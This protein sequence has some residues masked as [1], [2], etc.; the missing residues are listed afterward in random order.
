MRYFNLA[1]LFSTLIFI[2]SFAQTGQVLIE[3]PG[4]TI[5]EAGKSG[6]VQ[7]VAVV[8]NGLHIMSDHPGKDNFIPTSLTVTGTDDVQVLQIRYP[9]S[10][11]IQ[12][13][14]TWEYFNVFHDRVLFTVLVQVKQGSP[15]KIYVLEAELFYQACDAVKCYYPRSIKIPVRIS[16]K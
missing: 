4:L 3:D 16:V 14:G 9:E 2:N 6:I 13:E 7:L 11:S 10:D 1:L 8:K 15:K 5:I 12:L